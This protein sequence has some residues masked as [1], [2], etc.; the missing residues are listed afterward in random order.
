MTNSEFTKKLRSLV[1][2]QNRAIT[3]LQECEE[4]YERRYGVDPSSADDDQW[5]DAF[6][7][8]A[9]EKPSNVSAATVERGA[10]IYANLKPYMENEGD[11][12]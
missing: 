6:H 7:G 10:V 4:E 2:A 5:I 8:I 9:A 1:K 12:P 11:Q 3:L